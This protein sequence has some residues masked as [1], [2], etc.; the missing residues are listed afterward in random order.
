[1]MPDLRAVIYELLKSFLLRYLILLKDVRL[2]FLQGTSVSFLMKIC[3]DV[4]SLAIKIRDYSD[5][6]PRAISPES[7]RL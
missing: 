7:K 3:A 1:M 6:P 2:F 5:F 4:H